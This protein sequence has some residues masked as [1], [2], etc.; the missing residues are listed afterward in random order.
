LNLEVA[1]SGNKEWALWEEDILNLIVEKK[2]SLVVKGF[3]I[4]FSINF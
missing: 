2:I 4:G 3:L 1:S